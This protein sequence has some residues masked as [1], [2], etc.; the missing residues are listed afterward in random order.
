MHG[1]G[2]STERYTEVVM[3]ERCENQLVKIQGLGKLYLPVVVTSAS[4]DVT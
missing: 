2:A 3:W 4:P 1:I